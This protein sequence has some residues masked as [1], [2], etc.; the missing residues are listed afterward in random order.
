MSQDNDKEN[1]KQSR[2]SVKDMVD[3]IQINQNGIGAGDINKQNA[4]KPLEGVEGVSVKKLQAFFSDSSSKNDIA[5][6]RSGKEMIT[7]LG[8]NK[9]KIVLDNKNGQTDKRSENKN[10]ISLSE[11]MRS[12]N[13]NQQ[14]TIEDRADL[15]SSEQ[16]E[17]IENQDR[18]N[19]SS[20]QQ[21]NSS[22]TEGDASPQ[23]ET[24][25]PA[26]KASARKPDGKRRSS[27]LENRK[28]EAS[29]DSVNDE[30]RVIKDIRDHQKR[31]FH[32]TGMKGDKDYRDEAHSLKVIVKFI[33]HKDP[34]VDKIGALYSEKDTSNT[35]STES[36]FVIAA[37]GEC[38]F[39]KAAF[40]SLYRLG[41][42]EEFGDALAVLASN[43]VDN[44]KK[45]ENGKK[46]EMSQIIAAIQVLHLSESEHKKSSPRN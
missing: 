32:R 39:N 10:E 12:K 14:S 30:A 43:I 42:V 29:H 9:R 13:T 34:L 5:T 20:A 3:K 1:R 23:H 4:Q 40:S 21:I 16:I 24:E 45:I 27:Q 8:A 26:R 46:N 38:C 15:S 36:F 11:S 44:D 25:Q 6:P 2:P 35:R 28:H 19:I 7:S 33:K 37:T 31:G 18:A 41:K 17:S 22:Q